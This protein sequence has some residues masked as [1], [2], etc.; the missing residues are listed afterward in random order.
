MDKEHRPGGA[1]TGRAD[2]AGIEEGTFVDVRGLGQWVSL[3]GRDA[4]NPAL[5]IIPGFGAGLCSLAPFFAPWQK[6]FTLVYWDQPRAGATL[7]K[8]G[9]ADIGEYSIDRI[10]RDGIAVAE[11]ICRR[12]GTRR[13]AVLG[14]SGGTITGLLMMK[15]RPDLFCAYVGSGQVVNWARQD[16]LSYTML[17]EQARLA[18]KEDTIADLERIGPPPYADTATD[19]IKSKYAGAL[20]PAE[21]I[22]FASADPSVMAAVMSPPPGARYLPAGVNLGDPRM[23]AMAAYD[24]LRDAIVSF[25]ARSL[26]LDFA[27]P[28]FFLQGDRDVF[29]V[30]SEVRDYTAELR[31]PR[32]QFVAIEGGGHSAYFMRESFL[33][34]LNE[35]VRPTALAS[36]QP[37]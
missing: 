17:L 2:G 13:I 35:H 27:V 25:D 11:F 1:A 28:M 14:V 21:Q 6:T 23:T 16:A 10:A 22:A 32:T 30:T 29:T 26:G 33:D 31:A 5:L 4:A 36:V 3:R 24:A 12:L 9:G 37:R 18:G 8:H 7:W 19:A 15:Q 34:A 20:T